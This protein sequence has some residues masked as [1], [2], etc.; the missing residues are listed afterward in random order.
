M[1]RISPLRDDTI[2]EDEIRRDDD[3]GGERLD[4][5]ELLERLNDMTGKI[6]ELVEEHNRKEDQFERIID[7]LRES[8]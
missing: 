5:Y 7:I 8:Y 2:T 1:A 4:Y 3:D 6:D